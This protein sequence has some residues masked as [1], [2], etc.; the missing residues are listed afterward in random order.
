MK[1]EILIAGF[2][3]PGVMLMV[4]LLKIVSLNS[5]IIGLSRAFPKSNR[6]FLKINE[7]TAR[8]GFEQLA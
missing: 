6:N 7:K 4:W 3:G 2:G 5:A 8:L 1:S